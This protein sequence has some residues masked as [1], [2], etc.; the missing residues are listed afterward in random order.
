MGA[1]LEDRGDGDWVLLG[2]PSIEDDQ[3]RDCSGDAVVD[4]DGGRELRSGGIAVK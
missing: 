3:L 1:M 2:L 4:R